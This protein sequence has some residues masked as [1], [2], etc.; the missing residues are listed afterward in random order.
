MSLGPAEGAQGNKQL[1]FENLTVLFGAQGKQGCGQ[2]GIIHHYPLSP[3]MYLLP[4]RSLPS[5]A[6]SLTSKTCSMVNAETDPKPTKGA[7]SKQRKSRQRKNN[8]ISF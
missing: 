4:F 1:W 3:C 8:N 5:F 7:H 6:P 2:D